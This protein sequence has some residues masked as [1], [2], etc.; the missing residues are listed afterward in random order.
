MDGVWF[1]ASVSRGAVMGCAFSRDRDRA[2]SF[3]E[4]RL[5]GVA[6]SSRG[7]RG[8][9][10]TRIAVEAMQR[11]MRGLDPVED[12]PLDL[13]RLTGFKRRVLEMV[14]RIPRG[15]VSTYR[16]VASLIGCVKG[17][18]AVGAALRGNP[19]PLLIPCHRVVNSDLTIGGYTGLDGEG[20]WFKRRLLEVEGVKFRGRRVSAESLWRPGLEESR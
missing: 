6:V 8:E 3:L 2:L 10:L 1:A 5:G 14:S 15:Y 20:V 13:S 16:D 18:R 12:P 11:R 7:D 17:Y 4:G 19:F 9:G